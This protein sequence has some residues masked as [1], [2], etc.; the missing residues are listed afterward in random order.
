MAR[1]TW[2]SRIGF[3]LAAVGSAVGLGNIWRF[4]WMTAQNGG[5]AF[6]VTYLFIVIG[7]GVPGLL[8]T[9]VIGRRS[10]LNPVGAFKSLKGS[11]SW[12]LLGGI[13][14]L[15]SIVLISFYS[16]VGGWVLRYFI[17]SFTGAYFA[18]PGAHFEA[19]NY[20]MS[21]FQYQVVFLIIT[22][23][24]VMIGV[25]EGI[26]TTTKVM[27][28][29]IAVLLTAM[30]IWAFRQPNAAQGYQFY[31]AF[32][33]QYL[34]KNFLPVLS[35][36]AGQALF[37][38]SIGGG[39]M[40]T[41]ASYIEEDRSLPF[42]ASSIAILNLGIGVLA[43]LVVFPLLFSYADGPTSG[44]P[45]ALFVSIAGAFAN[46]PAGKF[47][48]ATFFLVVLLAAI[49]S[50]ISM[51][52]IPVAFLVDEFGFERSKV[53]RGM[54]LLVVATGA[55]NAFNAEVF[56]FVAGHL[57]SLLMTL[58]LIGFMFYAA[59]VLGPDAVEEYRK[60]AGSLARPLAGVW[61]YAIGSVFPIFLLFSFYTDSLSLA[62]VSVNSMEVLV[63]TLLTAVPFIIFIHW[64]ERET[65]SKAIKSTD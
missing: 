58:G 28:P 4:P 25:R 42:D 27:M 44:G 34:S 20:G 33:G 49:T 60:G 55:P 16:V 45:G 18:Q 43:G 51:L 37:T 39:T 13:C 29:G 54:F 19:I 48:G 1:D 6:L 40:L 62:G 59:W 11:R 10:N 56:S 31:L 26:E 21:A 3:I 32:D 2:A 65:P 24:I 38:L 61:R 46:L 9:L 50:S 7:V 36:A 23:L 17:E 22:A 12:V 57:V 30:A 53:T 5:S 35:S 63:I 52:E 41:Y 64:S 15:T 14:V 8:A 47:L